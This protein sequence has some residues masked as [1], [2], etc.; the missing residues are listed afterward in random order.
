MLTL[1]DFLDMLEAVGMGIGHGSP[2]RNR[3]IVILAP[4]AG[5]EFSR[6]GQVIVPP[7]P[8]DPLV[9]RVEEQTAD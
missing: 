5:S 9:L 7:G 2:D 1:G 4:A 3:E 8:D 6:V